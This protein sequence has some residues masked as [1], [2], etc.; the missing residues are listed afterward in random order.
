MATYLNSNAYDFDMFESRERAVVNNNARQVRTVREKTSAAVLRKV[1]EKSERHKK[2]DAIS[3][4]KKM[5]MMMV[6]AAF[7]FSLVC[8]QI[9]VGAQR[10][11]LT[12]EIESLEEQIATAKSESV[13][14]NAELNSMTSISKIDSFATEVLGMTKL[15]NYQVE[16]IDLSDGDQ[17][18]F[19]S[20]SILSSAK[21]KN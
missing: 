13:R 11:E 20:N 1:P 10:Y 16:Y 7:S 5:L 17:I 15:E 19:V 8:L 14:L 9:T 3:A 6:I 2:N 21:I 12:K 18:L 4:R